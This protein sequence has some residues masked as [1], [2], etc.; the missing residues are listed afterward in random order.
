MRHTASR[1]PAAL[2]ACLCLT[3]LATSAEVSAAAQQFSYSGSGELTSSAA[4]TAAAPS[5]VEQPQSHVFT[6]GSSFSISVTAVG[7]APLSYQWYKDAAPI[8]GAQQPSLL[9]ESASAADAASYTV[10]VTSAN[11]SVTS[12]AAVLTSRSSPPDPYG[13][14]LGVANLS[15]TSG[16]STFWRVTTDPDETHDG[17]SAVTT[18]QVFADSSY[19]ETQITGPVTFAFWARFGGATQISAE[20]DGHTVR[21]YHLDPNWRPRVQPPNVW[22]RHVLHIPPGTYALRLR[23][24]TYSGSYSGYASFDDFTVAAAP[25]S[26]G[27][28]LSDDWE[29]EIFGNLDANPT[30]D[31][32]DDLADNLQEYLDVTD[33]NSGSGE[34]GYLLRVYTSVEGDGSLSLSPPQGRF[35]YGRAWGGYV[36]PSVVATATPAPGTVFT[37]WHNEYG[38]DFF[39]NPLPLSYWSRSQIL[40]AVF[41]PEVALAAALD[42][43]EQTWSTG[44][45]APW[46]GQT[47]FSN[48]GQDAVM[49]GALPVI[50]GQKSWIETTVTGPAHVQYWRPPNHSV[51]PATLLDGQ[52]AQEFYRETQ[53]NGYRMSQFIRAGTH[54]LRWEMKSSTYPSSSN[55]MLL[56]QFSAVASVDSDQDALPDEWEQYFFRNLADD[57]TGDFDNDGVSNLDEY[58][59]ETLPN[60]F[61]SLRRPLTSEGVGGGTVTLNPNKPIY[62]YEEKVQ[63]T[64]V[65]NAGRRFEKWARGGGFGFLDDTTLTLNIEVRA[66]PQDRYHFIAFFG[67]SLDD[68]VDQ[69]NLGLEDTDRRWVTRSAETHDGSDSAEFIGTNNGPAVMSAQIQ[70]PVVVSFWWRSTGDPGSH[71]LRFAAANTSAPAFNPDV[72]FSGGTAWERRFVVLPSGLNTVSWTANRYEDMTQY[73]SP[74]PT[75]AWVDQLVIAADTDQDGLGDD[76]ETQYFGNLAANSAEDADSDGASNQQEFGDGT[77][78]TMA[79]SVK[80]HLHINSAEPGTISVTPPAGPYA[81]G[82]V[83]TIDGGPSLV[84][85]TGDVSTTTNPLSVTMDSNKTITAAFAALG[86]AVDCVQLPW[87]TGGDE[88]WVSGVDYSARDVARSGDAQSAGEQSWIE[89]TVTGPGVLKFSPTLSSGYDSNGQRASSFSWSVN[90]VR[91]GGIGEPSGETLILPEGNHTIRWLYIRGTEDA[92]LDAYAALDAVIWEPHT[93]VAL[94]EAL[95]TPGLVWKQ[96][97]TSAWFG[98]TEGSHDGQDVAASWRTPNYGE[99]WIET[100]VTGPS[101]LSYWCRTSTLAGS[102]QLLF[103]LN[104]AAVAQAPPTSG[105]TGWTKVEVPIPLG[106]HVARWTYKKSGTAYAEDRVWLDQ[107]A[108]TG[109]APVALEQALDGSNLVWATGGDKNWT[110]LAWNGSKD[111]EDAAI[112]GRVGDSQE[113]WLQTQVEGPG[114][115]SFSWKVSSEEYGDTLMFEVNGAAS[116]VPAISGEVDWTTKTVRLPAGTHTVRWTYRKDS[117]SVSGSDLALVDN[118]AFVPLQTISLATALD[119]ANLTWTSG[120]NAEWNGLA[121]AESKDGVDQAASGEIGDSSVS[122]VETTITGPGTLGFWW[123]VSC[124]SG[125]DYLKLLVDGVPGA[126]PISGEVNW[127]YVTVPI[128]SG[129]HTVRWAYE[130]DGVFSAGQDTGWVDMVSFS[131]DAQ[132]TPAPTVTPTPTATPAA[133]PLPTATAVPTATV[134][135][136]PTATPTVPPPDPSPTAQPTANPTATPLPTPRQLLNIATRLRV[137]TGENVLI[138]GLIVTGNDKKKIIIRAIGP[139]LSAVFD[140]AL[141][142][143]MLEL[144]Q[145]DTLLA[146]NDNW[147]DWQRQ[148]IADTTIPPGDNRE[149]AIVTSVDPGFYTAVMSGKGGATGIGVIEV[150]DLDQ[151]ADSKLANIASRGFVEAGDDVMIG[152][153]IVGGNGSADARILL[154][155]IGPSLGEAGIAGALQDPVMELRDANGDIVQEND[156]WQDNQP[157]DIAATSIPPGHP[158]ESAI[159]INLPSGNYTAVVRGKNGGIGVGLVEVYNLR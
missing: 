86:A 77:N 41:S 143:T 65:P 147:Q 101:V 93:G 38:T 107:V 35:G 126:A 15:W 48:D 140:G 110:G 98:E 9:F 122:W 100:E 94:A 67:A 63:L 151:A 47:R 40:K 109:A 3:L 146:S 125:W 145:G 142:D 76:W 97:G 141:Q 114:D 131:P 25:D 118:V 70:G 62:D 50:E 88:P 30:T 17:S 134:T 128:R 44:G 73:Y 11:G 129:T 80:Y 56:D 26:D 29:N 46:V 90:G 158:A 91:A 64:A 45:D 24:Q 79:T 61:N 4:Q 135:P 144:Y 51:Y 82:T 10:S 19:I 112:A 117:Y 102:N 55:R 130:K 75:G 37:G 18:G 57:G 68:A 34:E 116:T 8:G 92:T 42:A 96:G 22:T 148:E 53:G 89:T 124:E 157:L 103:K 123:K 111:G 153:L 132:P 78:P 87:T 120:G 28:G 6:V 54:T 1:S 133:T 59:Y 60:S 119:T 156:N 150:Y 14:A 152:G 7:Q 39:A 115:L 33:P 139:S 12:N 5:I 121:S 16:G 106:L 127:T 113:T 74:Q 85:W 58:T 52:P 2:W 159:V 155:A 49:S 136:L 83:V 13:P 36:Y 108:V 69:A 31:G 95:D 23:N 81:P 154:R 71:A 104:G 99:A 72:V 66:G 137:Q 84:R 32:D 149:S 27:D 105:E 21:E 43:P 20:L 138:G